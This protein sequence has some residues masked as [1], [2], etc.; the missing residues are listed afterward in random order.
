MGDAMPPIERIRVHNNHNNLDSDSDSNTRDNSDRATAVAVT[1]ALVGKTMTPSNTLWVSVYPR[2]AF[3]NTIHAT[4]LAL[5]L[6]PARS[7]R[8]YYFLTRTI[9]S[10]GILSTA[11]FKHNLRIHYKN[12]KNR[13]TQQRQ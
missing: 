6:L 5:T 2:H 11:H 7:V 12:N 9:E 8:K 3:I 10:L 4:G 13:N 1:M